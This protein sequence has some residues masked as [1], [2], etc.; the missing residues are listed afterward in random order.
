VA[1]AFKETETVFWEYGDPPPEAK[2][3]SWEGD[4]IL[5]MKNDLFLPAEILKKA[6]RGAINFHPAPPQ[7]RGLGGYVYGI[8]NG[9]SSYGIT[10]HHMTTTL[11]KGPII[12]VLRFPLFPCDTTSSLRERTGVFCIALLHE[13]LL[14]LENGKELPSADETWGEKLFTRKA[15]NEFLGQLRSNGAEHLCLR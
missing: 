7:Y 9:D 6:R 4:W 1:S 12:R 10:C 2:L 11:D 15:L 13:I 8:Y 3:A 5:S 14:Y